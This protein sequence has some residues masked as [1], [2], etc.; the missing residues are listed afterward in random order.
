MMGY[1]QD[2]GATVRGGQAGA[3]RVMAF[4]SWSLATRRK[5]AGVIIMTI[6]RA[7]TLR[8]RKTDN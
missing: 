1:R 2:A 7:G 5:D 8:N 6:F 4:P 3:W